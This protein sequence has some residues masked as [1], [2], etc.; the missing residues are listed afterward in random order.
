[1]AVTAVT[2]IIPM[3]NKKEVNDMNTNLLIG[4]LV[5]FT[6]TMLGAAMVFIMKNELSQNFQKMLLGFA[7]GVM[8][9]ASVWSL[10]LPSIDKAKERGD[11]AWLPASLGFLLGIAFL[12]LLD[13]IIPHLHRNSDEPEG[14]H[15]TVKKNTML[16][17]A[18]TL[19]NIPEGMAV[20]VVFAGFLANDSGISFPAAVALAVGIA[21]QNF[22]EG[23]I[24]SMPL[25]G[26][27]LSKKRAFFYGTLTGAV[28]PFAA[29]IT[30]LLTGVLVPVL[31]YLLAFAA[32]AMIYVVVEELIPELQEG[33]HSNI[34]IIGVA[35]GFVIMMILDIALG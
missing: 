20:G 7:S 16:L 17:L 10:L 2:A 28:E 27:G 6:G 11:V 23:A 33:K 15:T 8:M 1:M 14:I 3:I 21:I 4:L 34:G 29:V 35:A 5:P 24:V 25:V 30:I 19:H 18:V 9:S 22:P 12:L 32:G 31:P 13:Y 26:E